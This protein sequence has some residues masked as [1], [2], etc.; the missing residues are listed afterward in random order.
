MINVF[1]I[2]FKCIVVYILNVL[3]N[4]ACKNFIIIIICDIIVIF[5]IEMCVN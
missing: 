3:S 5:I 2:F 4:C 1:G